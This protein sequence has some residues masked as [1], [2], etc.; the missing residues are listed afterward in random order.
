MS[1][2]GMV[3]LFEN[4]AAHIT[5]REV[6]GLDENTEI[7]TLGLDS[8]GMLELVGEMERQL[9]VHLPDDQLVGLRTVRDLLDLVELRRSTDGCGAPRERTR[10]ARAPRL[11]TLRELLRRGRARAAL[12]PVPRHSVGAR[13]SRGEP[14]TR[15]VRGDVLRR[16]ELPARL[17]VEGH[18]RGARRASA[19]RGSRPTG[20]TRSPS[21][22]SR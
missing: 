20:P 15:A 2:E 12:E 7:S 3:E 13:Q 19:R 4:A 11:R 8:L 16:G 10:G 17:R 6:A 1:R 22:R 21:T 9:G 18:Q 14:C 5:E